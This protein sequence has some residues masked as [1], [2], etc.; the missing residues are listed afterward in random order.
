MTRWSIEG[1]CSVCLAALPADRGVAWCRRRCGGV[2]KALERAEAAGD[3]TKAARFRRIADELSAATAEAEGCED[4]WQL[5]HR[6]IAEAH[7]RRKSAAR[8]PA[9][10]TVRAEVPERSEPA[11]P[12][13][14]TA[15]PG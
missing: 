5:A 15:P 11:T 13:G 6:R 4:V 12:N 10:A 8:A 2:H 7:E 3:S 14:W 1:A 9:S